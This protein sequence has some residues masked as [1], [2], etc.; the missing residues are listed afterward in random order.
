M[1][2]RK[3]YSAIAVNAIIVKMFLTYPRFLIENSGNAAWISVLM[4]TMLALILFGAVI[5]FYTTKDN[6]IGIA[7]KIGGTWLR[8]L[9]GLTVFL[10]L[11]LNMIPMVYSFPKLIRLVLLQ[12]TYT[13]Y[14]CLAFIITIILGALCGIQSLGRVHELL[15]PISGVFIIAF[16][17][18]L[19]PSVKIDNIFPILGKGAAEVFIKGVSGLSVFTDILLLNMLIPHI[20]NLEEYKRGGVKAIIAGGIFVIISILMYGLCYNYPVTEKFLIPIYQL[21]RL[22]HLSNFFSRFEAIFQFMWSIQII[23]YGCV[24]L[25]VLSEVWQTTFRLNKN[26][27]IIMSIAEIAAGVSFLPG[28]MVAFSGFEQNIYQWTYIPAF[29]LPILFGLISK[30]KNH[31]Q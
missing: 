3:Q 13:E 4:C 1:V 17:L 22:I 12:G 2:T 26:T 23:L 31:K 25:A 16:F 19:I 8:I 27:P 21:E 6:I 15:I 10:L 28:S 11:G 20:K 14:I 5:F 18:L 30:L 24:Y 29:I 9:T 7:D